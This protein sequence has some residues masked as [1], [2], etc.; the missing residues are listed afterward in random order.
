MNF[1]TIISLNFFIL[2]FTFN[3]N[4]QFWKCKKRKNVKTELIESANPIIS[5]KYKDVR[6]KYD[7]LFTEIDSLIDLYQTIEV[8][9]KIEEVLALAQKENEH[10][11]FY[12]GILYQV[13]NKDWGEDVYEIAENKW[14]FADSIA[15]TANNEIKPFLNLIKAQL[16]YDLFENNIFYFENKVFDDNSKK[17]KI[18]EQQQ[19]S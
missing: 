18:L 16:L 10:G 14:N 17:S 3:S 5:E 4:A 7:K 9:K 6:N 1:K 2:L 11:Y 19:T 15:K 13:G 12:K 8:N